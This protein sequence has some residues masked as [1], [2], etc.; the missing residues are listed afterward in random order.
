MNKKYSKWMFI[1]AWVFVIGGIFGFIYEEIFYRIDLGYW[2]KR[3]TTFG[4]WV[5]IYAFGALLVLISTYK[6][7]KKPILVFLTSMLICG[8]LELGTGIVLDNVFHQRLWDYNTEIWNWLNI[9]GYIC[10]R[11]VVF[12]G[13]SGMLLQYII[14]PFLEICNNKLTNKTIRI[15]SYIPSILLILDIILYRILV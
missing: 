3:G 2:V 6:M 5:P 4:P 7:R 8:L 15:F 13:I 9:G 10:F 12:F 1:L 11:S 14:Y